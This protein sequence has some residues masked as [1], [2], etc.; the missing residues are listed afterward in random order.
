MAGEEI[1]CI[2]FILN[3]IIHGL[4]EYLRLVQNILTFIVII[5]ASLTL[6]LCCKCG[7]ASHARTLWMNQNS[8]TLYLYVTYLI[9]TNVSTLLTCIHIIRCIS[10][11]YNYNY[12][13]E[14]AEERTLKLRKNSWCLAKILPIEHISLRIQDYSPLWPARG[15]QSTSSLWK[16]LPIPGV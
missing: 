8:Y 5:K 3:L 14:E 13:T 10:Y 1:F 12:C 11:I 2:C 6:L 7:Q 4:K 9:L 15:F 16:S